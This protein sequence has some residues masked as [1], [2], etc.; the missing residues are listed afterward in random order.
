MSNKNKN[1]G[2][3]WE[4]ELAKHLSQITGLSFVRVPNSGAF[5]GGKNQ[6]RT[7]QLSQE[8]QLLMNGDIIMP[9]EWKDVTIECK[10]FKKIGWQKLFDSEGE[11]NLNKWI[12]QVEVCN[13]PLWF[14]CFKINNNGSYIL[15]KE[16]SLKLFKYSNSLRYKKDYVIVS[17]DNFF[18]ENKEVIT[19]K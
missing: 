2:K 18:E 10:F 13:K 15:F 4:R 19:Q 3:G 14:I 1:K 6:F 11:S 12:E 7:N 9:I 16:S 17:L 5:V 8:Q